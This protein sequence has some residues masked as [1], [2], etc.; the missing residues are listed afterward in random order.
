MKLGDW[1]KDRYGVTDLS[2][3]RL[4]HTPGQWKKGWRHLYEREGRV[5]YKIVKD[6]TIHA[7]LNSSNNFCIPQG[8]Y[9]KNLDF[10]CASP[11]IVQLKY[12]K[13]ETPQSFIVRPTFIHPT[14]RE[15][16]ERRAKV[17]KAM[18]KVEASMEIKPFQNC[19]VQVYIQGEV[20]ECLFLQKPFVRTFL[21]MNEQRLWNGIVQLPEEVRAAEDIPNVVGVFTPE[22]LEAAEKVECFYLV[23]GDHVFSWLLCVDEDYLKTK[24]IWCKKIRIKPVDENDAYNLFFIIPKHHLRIVF[25]KCMEEFINGKIDRRDLRHVGVEMY[26][27]HNQRC[28]PEGVQISATIVFSAH[29]ENCPDNLVIPALDPEFPSYYTTQEWQLYEAKIMQEMQEAQKVKR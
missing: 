17:L 12:V 2:H 6:T 8:N 28:N 20:D 26:N 13:N 22:G 11:R 16:M 21:L 5:G 25:H 19:D 15:L 14:M 27:D 7:K 1:I 10:T 3:L 29:P 4:V 18:N 9:G 23:P 24:G